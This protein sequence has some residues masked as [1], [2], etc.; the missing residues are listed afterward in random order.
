MAN[1]TLEDIQNQVD[2]A[3]TLA[4][5][6]DETVTGSDILD[7]LA[8]MGAI[9]TLVTPW[10]DNADLPRLAYTYTLTPERVEQYLEN[11]V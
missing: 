9:I 8:S 10:E 7:A 5:L 2:L 4:E 11:G 3:I 6:T 1:P